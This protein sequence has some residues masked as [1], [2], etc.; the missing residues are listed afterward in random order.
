MPI[1]R[2]ASNKRFEDCAELDVR[3]AKINFTD[4]TMKLTS[5][6]QSLVDVEEEI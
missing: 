1:N 3:A 2:V 4:H 6:G 5:T